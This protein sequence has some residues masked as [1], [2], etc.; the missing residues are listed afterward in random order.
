M[1]VLINLFINVFF[2]SCWFVVDWNVR[3]ALAS[4]DV[5]NDDVVTEKIQ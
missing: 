5:R 3:S 4:V 2:P 1:H